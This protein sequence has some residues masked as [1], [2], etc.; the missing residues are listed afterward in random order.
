MPIRDWFSIPKWLNRLTLYF[1]FFVIVI[2]TSHFVFSYFGFL[3]TD[4]DSARYMLSAL[5]QSEAAIVAL[6]VTLSLVVMQ[7]A[8][9]S[10]SARLIDVF[11]RTPDLW[12]LILIYGIAIFYGLGVLKLLNR[13]YPLADPPLNNLSN[14]E[15][16]I[17]L[18]YYL[19][20]FAFVALILY[21]LHTIELL[22]PST[23]IKM[24]ADRITRDN[25]LNSIG[26]ETEERMDPKYGLV[27][28][29]RGHVYIENDPVQ[30]IIDII[31]NSLMKYDHATLRYCVRAITERTEY[32]FK[33]ERLE[34]LE[35]KKVLIHL[36]SH[37]ANIGAIAASKQDEAS[38]K[39]LIA[40]LQI[41][42]EIA[43]KEKLK[44][45]LEPVIFSLSE[46]GIIAAEKKLSSA[47]QNVSFSLEDIG[48]IA[49]KEKE[50][51]Y[52]TQEIAIILRDVG[53]AA[54][55]QK[56]HS[57]LLN[58]VL[59]LRDFGLAASEQELLETTKIVA[60]SLKFVGEVAAEQGLIEASNW[61]EE[62]F[63][64]INEAI[65]RIEK[66]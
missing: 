64:N 49:T 40:N 7:L 19:G 18:S 28:V 48:I 45:A 33:N 57:A 27:H 53:I 41:N 65:K 26:M 35:R 60:S 44:Y 36:S 16:H 5:I 29:S 25:I 39:I 13:V 50:L 15:A 14:L 12:I 3:H 46:I 31:F 34:R 66:T 43:V 6:V 20:I 22:K 54:A 37:L 4:I 61:A 8:A 9:S 2:S 30:P 38:A 32:I 23:I 11:R 55:Q 47:L 24:L 21:I 52:E 1:I 56:L 17:S 63:E 59:S 51:V 42:G 10:Y 62:F 58:I